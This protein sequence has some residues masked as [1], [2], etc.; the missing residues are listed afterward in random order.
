MMSIVIPIL[1]ALSLVEMPFPMEHSFN[2]N[3]FRFLLD[4][5][6]WGFH[7]RSGSNL[8]LDS[9]G[10]VVIVGVHPICVVI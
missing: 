3:K 6:V 10:F 2:S 4:M 7:T 1:N 5:Y 8:A 9:E